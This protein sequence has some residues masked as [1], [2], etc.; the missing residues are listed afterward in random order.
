[1]APRSQVTAFAA[2]ADADAAVR[3]LG[4]LRAR[5][6]D[7]LTGFELIGA[8][9]LALCRKHHPALPDPLPGHP[10]YVRVQA[11]DA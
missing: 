10:W 5:L 6:A 8:L 7:R 1:P 2:V 9:P 4:M 3:L 11:D